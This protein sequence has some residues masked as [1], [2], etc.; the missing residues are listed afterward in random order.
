[1]YQV[2]VSKIFKTR[3]FVSAWFPYVLLRD[4]EADYFPGCLRIRK[5]QW[6]GSERYCLEADAV[7]VYAIP[8]L[9]IRERERYHSQH[10]AYAPIHQ[11]GLNTM[12]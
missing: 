7:L 11:I 2:Y 12:L 3:S 10:A 6:V 9:V 8:I 1:M 5:R 4:S